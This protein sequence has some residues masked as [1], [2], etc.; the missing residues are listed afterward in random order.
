[1][2]RK[3]E[4]EKYIRKRARKEQDC[5]FYTKAH[6]T[7]TSQ[8]IELVNDYKRNAEI[9]IKHIIMTDA[10]QK[11]LAGKLEWFISSQYFVMINYKYCPLHNPSPQ[12]YIL[13]ERS[14]KI[15]HK[16]CRAHII[17]SAL[18]VKFLIDFNILLITFIGFS[19]WFVNFS[20]LPEWGSSLQILIMSVFLL[21]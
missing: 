14:C 11:H 17:V 7:V 3:R 19:G 15:S 21:S 9:A 18:A 2:E 1:M 6:W 8:S 16:D 4:K 12:E 20:L 13:S 5:F 10:E